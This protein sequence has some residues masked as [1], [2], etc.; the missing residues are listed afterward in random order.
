MIGV[1]LFIM[2]IISGGKID[3]DDINGD[4]NYSVMTAY[5]QSKLANV[6]F[7][8]ELSRQLDGKPFIKGNG[9]FLRAANFIKNVFVSLLKRALL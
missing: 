5:C 7:T 9:Y 8:R 2:L 6:L 3:F 1:I 4:K